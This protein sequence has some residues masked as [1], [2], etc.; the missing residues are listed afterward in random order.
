MGRYMNI[1]TIS[2]LIL[3][4]SVML[5]S[6]SDKSQ[7]VQKSAENTPW[8]G[9]RI[10]DLPEKR[11]ADLKIDHGVEIV[12]VYQSSPAEKAGLE[13]DDILLRFNGK[14]IDEVDDLIDRVQDTKIDD[15]VK[16][17]YLRN[18][19]EKETTATIAGKQKKTWKK[20]YGWFR[21]GEKYKDKLFKYKDDHAWMGVSTEELTD[22]LRAYF[23]VPEDA[24]ILISEVAENSPAEECGLQAGDII[25]S[26]NK[27]EISDYYD[28]IKILDRY[29]PEDE[30]EI[31]IIRDRQ[32]KAIK[33][34][35]GKQEGRIRYHYGFSPHKFD[36]D[37]PEIEIEIP[38]F[39]IELPEINKEEF[40]ELHEQIREEL[41]IN[42]ESLEK[43]MEK[44]HEQ[45]KNLHV[46]IKKN[47]SRVI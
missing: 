29:D 5:T 35:L 11:L 26:I 7:L 40:R 3:F 12:K 19:E 27:K 32:Q 47:Q 10:K 30:I 8:F 1:I 44:L 24:G 13:V 41:E 23:H 38:E 25:I 9:V 15:H 18:G 16:I 22:Q 17:T 21:P 31:S 43:E 42:K 28:L 2:L 14:T 46:K 4:I 39:E 45:L 34:I 37:V 33:M 36:F 6:C 20:L